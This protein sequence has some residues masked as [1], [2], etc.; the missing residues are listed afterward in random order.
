MKKC[1]LAVLVLMAVTPATAEIN[2]Q[3]IHCEYWR[4][5][6]WDDWCPDNWA[7]DF[8]GESKAD[9]AN[10]P[11][12]EVPSDG[13]YYFNSATTGAGVHIFILDTGIDP[14]NPDFQVLDDPNDDRVGSWYKDPNLIW[15]EGDGNAGS[16]GTRVAALAA[17]LR[18][19]V[20]KGATIRPIYTSGRLNASGAGEIKKRLEWI[21]AE[22]NAA[23][24]TRAVLN[25]SFNI[26]RPVPEESALTSLVQQLISSGV[27]VTVSAGNQNSSR[28]QDY[29]PSNIADVI[30]VGGL[31]TEGNRWQ[32]AADDEQDLCTGPVKDCGSNFGEAVDVWAPAEHI[33]SALK[34][35]DL[36]DEPARSGTSYAAPIVAGLAAVHL[37]QNPYDS[38]V[39]VLAA[40]KANAA[41]RSV[42][43]D[44]GGTLEYLVR[45]PEITPACNILQRMFAA[46]DRWTRF[47]SEQMADSCP[48][49]FDAYSDWNANHG[50]IDIGGFGPGGALYFYTPNA[51]YEGTDHSNYTIYNDAG[52]PSGTG[53]IKI[54]V[55]PPHN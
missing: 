9:I 45:S 34:K 41:R 16:H 26:P 31:N 25:M 22:V 2:G 50:V 33:R 28:P 14:M 30:V 20:A 5:P 39:Q 48:E 13:K 18:F 49:G 36:S 44:I 51:S 37:Q 40:L 7:L 52:N 11:F 47:L 29:W 6:D 54:T 4:L 17:G 3:F 35:H 15:P 8:L 21:L 23:P 24:S 27:V 10:V 55:Q 1:F 42:D 12:G 53:T 38:P 46:N 19:G 43:G 32:R